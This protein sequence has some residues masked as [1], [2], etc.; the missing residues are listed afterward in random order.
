[1]TSDK[2]AHS[3]NNLIGVAMYLAA[4]FLFAV[5]GV[6]SK[7]VLNAGLDPGHLT[8]LRNGGAAILLVLYVALFQRSG[9]RIRKGE[10]GFLILYGVL[11]FT[12]VQFL[13]FVTISRLPVGIGTLFAF[14]APVVVA[15]Y[16]KFVRG[17]SVGRRI[18]LGIVLTLLGL[19]LVAQVW[20]GMTLDPLGV[21]AGLTL[22]VALSS[23]WVL[24]ERGQQQRD[25]VSLTMWGF[26]FASAAWLIVLPWWNFPVDV[27]TTTAEPLLA[28]TPGLPVWVLMLWGIVLGTIAPFLLVLGSLRRIGAQRAGIVGTTEP[29]WAGLIALAL[30]GETFTAIQGV[31]GLIVLAGVIVAETAREPQLDAEIEREFG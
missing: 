15:L 31:G 28:G 19:A 30:L 3:R 23:Y 6:F 2:A 7:D 20:R 5:N 11:A 10:W 22:A 26:V 18:W 25:P 14:L 12:C 21:A 13:Y 29:L 1:M 27:M 17:V 16:L 24:G 8:Q 9:L 4:A